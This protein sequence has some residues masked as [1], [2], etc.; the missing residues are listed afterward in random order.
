MGAIYK[1]GKKYGG[2]FTGPAMDTTCDTSETVF[3]SNNVQ[4]VIEEISEIFSQNSIGQHSIKN[5]CVGINPT[6]NKT[7]LI[8]SWNDGSVDQLGYIDFTN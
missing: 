5:I 7:A 4:G 3:K 1:N 2:Y 8:V 6:T